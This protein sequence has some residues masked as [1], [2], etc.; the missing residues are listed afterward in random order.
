MN[1]IALLLREQI[2]VLEDIWPH[3]C[4][5]QTKDPVTELLEQQTKSLEY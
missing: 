3:I 5:E 1:L 4:H 2:I